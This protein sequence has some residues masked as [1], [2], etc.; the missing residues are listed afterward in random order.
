MNVVTTRRYKIALLLMIALVCGLSVYS[1]VINERIHVVNQMLDREKLRGET[2]LG[3]KLTIEKALVRANV[4]LASFKN[5][6]YNNAQSPGV[7]RTAPASVVNSERT[8]E[9]EGK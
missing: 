9:T 1:Y 3:E 7:G 6:N 2:L 4:R 8:R 5:M